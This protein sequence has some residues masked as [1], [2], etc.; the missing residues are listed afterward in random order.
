M[1]RKDTVSIYI[2]ITLFDKIM[3][4]SKDTEFTVSGYIIYV[5]EQVLLDEVY[6]KEDEEKIKGRLRKLGYL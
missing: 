5:L 4:R 3:R 6:S 1:R 2:P